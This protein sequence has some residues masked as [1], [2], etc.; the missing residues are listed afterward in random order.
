MNEW[1]EEFPVVLS[2]TVDQLFA[3]AA[4]IVQIGIRAKR[5]EKAE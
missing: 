3:A 4:T 1:I 5:K 2:M